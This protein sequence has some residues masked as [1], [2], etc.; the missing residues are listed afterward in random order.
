MADEVLYRGLVV[1][2][3]LGNDLEGLA[4]EILDQGA[5]GGVPGLIS[6]WMIR[7]M[8]L[9]PGSLSP[10]PGAILPVDSGSSRMPGTKGYHLLLIRRLAH[11]S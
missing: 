5:P 10:T 8:V 4:A 9:M 2:V 7:G 11:K 1:Q 3:D 6:E